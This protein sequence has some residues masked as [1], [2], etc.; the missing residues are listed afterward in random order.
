MTT[1]LRDYTLDYVEEDI[2]VDDSSIL[3]DDNG[4]LECEFC[5]SILD[6]N[7][8]L[9]I[10]EDSWS[11]MDGTDYVVIGCNCGHNHILRLE[12]L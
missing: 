6:K 9:I 4:E 1:T 8:I 3:Y 10:F 12:Y 5:G 11:S 2:L 7:N